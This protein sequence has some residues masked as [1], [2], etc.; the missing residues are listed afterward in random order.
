MSGIDPHSVIRGIH[1]KELT[2]FTGNINKP[3]LPAIPPMKGITEVKE[4]RFT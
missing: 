1:Q 3:R 2:C 4:V